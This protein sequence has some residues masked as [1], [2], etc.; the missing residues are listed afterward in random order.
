TVALLGIGFLA[1]S[2]ILV[3]Q[4]MQI[5]E[6]QYQVVETYSNTILQEIQDGIMV[7]DDESGIKIYNQA[8]W[9]IFHERS[10]EVLGTNAPAFLNRVGC[11]EIL[12]TEDSVR[13]IHCVIRKQLH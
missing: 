7:Y 8:A 9:E 4:N 5:L 1:F 3:R 13:E 10:E 12:H 6:R 2:A 11:S